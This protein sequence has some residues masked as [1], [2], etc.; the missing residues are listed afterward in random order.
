MSVQQAAFAYVGAFVDELARSG[1]QHVCICPGSRS[2]P[3]AML[4][5]DHP[6]LRIWTHIDERSAGFFALGLAKATGQPVALVATSGTA[7]V[8]FMPAVVEAFFS[9]VPLILLTADRPHELR[10]VG[11]NQTIDQVRL[12]G[13][14]VKWAIDMPLPE[15]E[16]TMV[17]YA[18]MMA[19]RAAATARAVPAGPVHLNFPLREPLIPLPGPTAAA[20]AAVRARTTDAVRSKRTS[21]AAAHDRVANAAIHARVANAAVHAPVTS[22]MPYTRV[23]DGPRTLSPA[24][25][26]ELA[27]VWRKVERGVIVCG[28]DTPADAAAPLL[29]LAGLLSWPV[30]AD[31]LSGLRT[32]PGGPSSPGEA[33]AAQDAAV[34][35]DAYDVFLRGEDAVTTLAPEL[36]V[37][38]GALPVSKPLL[39][40]LQHYADVPQI[41]VDGGAGWR[42]PVLAAA[43]MLH[44][45]P[46]QL[47]EALVQQ[48]DSSARDDGASNGSSAN[49]N[50]PNGSSPSGS[51]PNVSAPNRSSA[52]DGAH[53]GTA[54]WVARWRHLNT[55]TRTALRQAVDEQSDMFEGRVFQELAELLPDGGAL[56]VGNS[57]PIR[58]MDAFFPV[59]DR[60]LR[61]F[62][63][64]GASGIDGIVSSALGAS[65]GVGGPLVLVLGDLS[66]YHDLNGLLAAKLHK[67]NITIVVINNDGGGIFSFLPQAEHP[68]HFELLFGTPIG[69]DFE[70]AVRMYGGEFTRVGDWNEFRR[71]LAQGVENDGLHVIEIVTE[72]TR[73]AQQHR[74]VTGAARAAV[75]A[76]LRVEA[77]ATGA[78]AGVKSGADGG[79]EAEGS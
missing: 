49:D 76:A 47:C 20:D 18:R 55:T 71:A 64:R 37:R 56:Y 22:G 46:R 69:L 53:G 51:A 63:N 62:G 70:P 21:D 48:L 34:I 8:N 41:V 68:D 31:P 38:F 67:L 73:N 27:A 2:T 78:E 65:A 35:I 28:P 42:D 10:D 45:D 11:T 60:R 33:D 1:V 58:D 26:A 16:E 23:V 50:T 32:A 66:F 12:Y 29:A 59:I 5:A 25:A 72:R 30:L 61:V 44:V 57:M 3:L 74:Q 4:C 54:D 13:S 40:Y 39:Q 43:A 79:N 7:V 19:D 17:R 6:D 24:D 15:A 36:V 9:R 14:H 75:S 52:E 77:A